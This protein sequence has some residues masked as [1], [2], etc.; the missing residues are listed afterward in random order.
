MS[1]PKGLITPYLRTLVATA[2]PGV[3]FDMDPL[4][5]LEL[6]KRRSRG[7]E[8]EQQATADV[9]E[10]GLDGLHQQGAQRSTYLNQL[11]TTIL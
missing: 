5:K 2:M 3:G 7:G 9:R 6:H 4:G 1:N 10:R 11:E 8:L